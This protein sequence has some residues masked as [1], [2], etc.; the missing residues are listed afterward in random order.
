MDVN[1]RVRALE[2]LDFIDGLM[3]THSRLAKNLKCNLKICTENDFPARILIQSMNL[4]RVTN[5]LITNAIKHTPN[6]KVD[7]KI[8]LITF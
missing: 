7:V 2:S 3:R 1:E 6:G 8:E 4:K 5:N